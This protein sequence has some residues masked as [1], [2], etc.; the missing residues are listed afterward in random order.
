[1]LRW[2]A[3]LEAS[4]A[5]NDFGRYGKP[6]RATTVSGFDNYYYAGFWFPSFSLHQS[7]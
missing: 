4:G 3:R 7:W 1:M 5:H 6:R 2:V